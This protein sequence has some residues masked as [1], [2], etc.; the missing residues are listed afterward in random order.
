[1]CRRRRAARRPRLTLPQRGPVRPRLAR[2]GV[3]PML[4]SAIPVL[5]LRTA[6]TPTIAQSC[7][8]R[9]NFWNDHPAP[10]NFGTRISVSSSSGASA[11]SRKP[12]KKSPA[13]IVRSPLLDRATSVP[14]KASTT[15]GRSEAGSECASEP[16]SVPRWRT[17]G[18]PTWLAAWARSGTCCLSR[19]EVSTSR[20]RVSAPIAMWS[21]PSLM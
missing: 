5:P 18:S 6:A 16:P 4:T 20:W 10:G 17:C 15:A 9:L 8:R 2:R 21:P 19:S 7:A 1:M 11:D 13:A 3:E 12:V 14:P